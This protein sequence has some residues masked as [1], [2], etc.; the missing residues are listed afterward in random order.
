MENLKESPSDVTGASMH[1]IVP[2]PFYDHGGITIYHGDCRLIVPVIGEFDLLLTDPPYGMDYKPTQASHK[3][4]RTKR[5]W[6]AVHDD[7][8][9]FDPSEWMKYKHC[10]LWGANWFCD[11]LPPKGGWFVFNK[12]GD[13]KPSANDFGDCEIAWT[14]LDTKPLRMYST[15]WHGTARWS[16]EPVLHP[17]QKPVSLME[18]CL[19]WFPESKS[20]LDPFMGS[21][22]TLVAAKA[23]GLRAVGIE[24]SEEYCEKAADR[25][26]QGVLF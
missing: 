3:P 1:P 4:N 16:R 21:G 18:W 8:K 22:S 9:P 15:V 14:S 24:I 6:S 5:V 19:T 23:A 26:Q 11:K 12:R 13:G 20:V 17:T 2:R 25:L 10:V 7:N